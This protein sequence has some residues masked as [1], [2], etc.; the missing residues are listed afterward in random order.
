MCIRDRRTAIVNTLKDKMTNAIIAT[1]IHDNDSWNNYLN[2]MSRDK[3]W[4][5]SLTLIGAS[6]KYQMKIT[7]IYLNEDLSDLVDTVIE[8]PPHS[9]TSDYT[10]DRN[11]TMGYIRGKHYVSTEELN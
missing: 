11:I 3:I 6:I 5:D 4:G 8:P 7:L 9:R 1:L 2:Y 10:S